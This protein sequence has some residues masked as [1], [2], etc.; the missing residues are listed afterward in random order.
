MSDDTAPA[1]P[2]SEPL[3]PPPEATTHFKPLP[4]PVQSGI[5]PS[6]TIVEPPRTPNPINPATDNQGNNALED[7]VTERATGTGMAIDSGPPS[8]TITTPQEDPS[9]PPLPQDAPVPPSPKAADEPPPVLPPDAI[10]PAVSTPTVILTEEQAMEPAGAVEP[11]QANGEAATAPLPL[12]EEPVENPPA[13]APALSAPPPPVD[14]VDQTLPIPAPSANH[15]ESSAPPV[16]PIPETAQS[17]SNAME[18]DPV[19]TGDISQNDL[20]SSASTQ[21]LKRPGE[22]LDG[23]EEK[24][25]RDDV[26]GIDQTAIAAPAPAPA[27]TPA[28]AEQSLPAVAPPTDLPLNVVPNY[29]PPPPEPAGPATPLTLTQHKHLLGGIRALKK[30]KE[31]AF[32]AEPVNPVLQGIPHYP[33]IISK[34]M[35]LG[36]VET[37]LIVSD[38]RG[39]PKDKSRMKNWDESKG[40]YRSVQDVV[41]DVRQIWWNTAR[42]NGRDHFVTQG[43]D[44][45]GAIFDRTLVNLPAEVSRTLAETKCL[46]LTQPARRHPATHAVA[47]RGRT[48]FTATSLH[49]ATTYHSPYIR[50]HRP[51]QA[52]NPPTSFERSLL[53][54]S[55]R[56]T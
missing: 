15:E 46:R 52:R 50:W 17:S 18:V 5:Q 38:P 55:T 42:F 31:Y 2:P 33:Q 43:G 32:F 26:G 54:G 56:Y 49:I 20:T 21:S 23:R 24:R 22:E 10:P 47:R 1:L 48:F 28:P 34:P 36:T 11:T 39:P 19:V 16:Q 37:K 41:L 35:D 13:S 3:P 53:C 45:L 8:A 12:P 4:T 30:I 40:S 51:S 9:L 14:S 25:A 6:S 27:P 29:E 7:A 44:K